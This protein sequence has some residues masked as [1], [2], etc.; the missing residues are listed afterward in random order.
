[1][2][3]KGQDHYL[4]FAKGHSVFKLKSVFSQKNVKLFKTISRESFKE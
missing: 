1:M 4:T 2:N 3:I